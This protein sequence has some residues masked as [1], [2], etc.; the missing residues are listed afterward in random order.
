MKVTI[1][2]YAGKDYPLG[3]KG[4][5]KFYDEQKAAIRR[6]LE[7]RSEDVIEI[8]EGETLPVSRV[9]IHNIVYAE[10]ASLPVPNA[11]IIAHRLVELKFLR[12][13]LSSLLTFR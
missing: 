9:R 8:Q 11:G 3:M 7:L 2:Q 12:S 1:E 5:P 10:I 6:R 4:N 13:L